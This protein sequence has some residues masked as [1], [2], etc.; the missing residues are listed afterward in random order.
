[1]ARH[2]DPPG[3]RFVIA[4]CGLQHRLFSPVAHTRRALAA[5][6]AT[7]PIKNGPAIKSENSLGHAGARWIQSTQAILELP[8]DCEHSM[9]YV[10]VLFLSV[11]SSNHGSRPCGRS[12]HARLVGA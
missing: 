10:H 4:R 7:K 6:M 1:M 3:G 2:L 8:L 5:T 11:G 9:N 12:R